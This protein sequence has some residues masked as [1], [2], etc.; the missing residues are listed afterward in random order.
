MR[1]T[2]HASPE[3]PMRSV[4][5]ALSVI[6]MTGCASSGPGTDAPAAVGAADAQATM[7]MIVINRSTSPVTA[8]AQWRSG[9]RV[10]LGEVR[11][12][13]TRRFT[14]NFRSSEVWLSVD[15]LSAP[16]VGTQTG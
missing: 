8:Y 12:S 14:T 15:V 7:D 10:P 2:R 13:S 1:Q 6:V 11:A 3:V 5:V 4:A 9:P 16:S